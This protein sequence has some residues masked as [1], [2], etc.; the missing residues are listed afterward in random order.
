MRKQLTEKCGDLRGRLKAQWWET[1]LTEKGGDLGN[2]LKSWKVIMRPK[3]EKPFP[4]EGI[5][6]LHA[7]IQFICEAIDHTRKRDEVKHFHMLAN[8]H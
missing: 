8:C 1:E 4:F 6:K 7:W 3:K 2:E 5:R